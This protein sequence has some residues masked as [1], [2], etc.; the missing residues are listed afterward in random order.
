[1]FDP[2]EPMPPDTDLERLASVNRA[3]KAAL[4]EKDE[5]IRTL[6]HSQPA[7]SDDPIDVL[8]TQEALERIAAVIGWKRLAIIVRN[9]AFIEGETV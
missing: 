9:L 8:S 1:M 6:L 7:R 4:A 5:V 3:Q 2:P